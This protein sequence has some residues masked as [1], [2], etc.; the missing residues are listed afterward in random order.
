MKRIT[1][2]RRLTVETLVRYSKAVGNRLV[3]SLADH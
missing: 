1:R 2:S 3:V